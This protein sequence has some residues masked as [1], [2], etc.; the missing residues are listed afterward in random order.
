MGNN[1]SKCSLEKKNN[2]DNLT[3]YD[4]T[5]F[6]QK[7]EKVFWGTIAICIIYALIGFIIFISSYLSENVKAILLNR[8]LPFTIVFIVGTIII[9]FFLAY[10][11]NDFKPIRI[12]KSA[13]YDDL[14]CPDYWKLERVPIDLTNGDQRN[15]FDKNINPNLFT[16]KCVMD[17]KLFKK[18]DIAYKKNE[19]LKLANANF[20][21]D[22]V[23]DNTN[24]SI[25]TNDKYLYANLVTSNNVFYKDVAKNNANVAELMKHSLIMNNYTNLNPNNNETNEIKFEYNITTD[26]RNRVANELGIYKINND[27]NV[28]NGNP[29]LLAPDTTHKNL[30]INLDSTKKN[31]EN[32]TIANGV[33]TNN[34]PLVC[35]R[36]YPLYLATKDIELSKNNSKL[37]QNTLRCAYSKICGVPWTDLNCGKYET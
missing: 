2:G 36:V 34:L 23:T 35:D 6:N 20:N 12:D 5:I 21:D 27:F 33:T 15:L 25:N 11:V 3:D 4:L 31:I 9:V 14:S 28:G 18:G 10:Q 26:D 1:T 13:S 22:K 16:Y 37:D 32:I 19:L 24:S 7:R 8:F 29:D 17:D 30:S